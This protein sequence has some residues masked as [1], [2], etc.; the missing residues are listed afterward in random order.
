M[1]CNLCGAKEASV[2]L[3]EIV[4]GQM[5]EIHICDECAAEK[6]TDFKTHFNFMDLFGDF[7]LLSQEPKSVFEAEGLKCKQCGMTFEEFGKGGRLGCS[8]CYDSFSNQLLPL[9][10]RVQR[11]VRHTG[12][13]PGKAAPSSRVPQGLEALQERLRQSVQKE[14]FEEAAR[15]R[16]EIKKMEQAPPKG[17]KK[18]SE[19]S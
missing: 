12:K 13:K 9:I 3:T 5:F 11:S 1:I 2:H 14:E 18:K 10:K 17:R 6:G 19:P 4:N 8:K 16:D 7:G 15:I